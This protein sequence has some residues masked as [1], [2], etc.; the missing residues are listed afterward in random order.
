L[1]LASMK[2]AQV[3]MVIMVVAGLEQAAF[4]QSSPADLSKRSQIRRHEIKSQGSAVEL[5]AGSTDMLISGDAM[6]IKNRHLGNYLASCTSC[7]GITTRDDGIKGTCDN[8]VKQTGGCLYTTN[9]CLSGSYHIIKVGAD[10]GT[11]IHS[12]DLVIIKSLPNNC[13]DSDFYSYLGVCGES[14]N[15]DCQDTS[16]HVRLYEAN[17]TNPVVLGPL[18]DNMMWTISK[19][20]GTGPVLLGAGEYVKFM[21]AQSN[22]DE[23]GAGSVLAVCGECN[24]GTCSA[25]NLCGARNNVYTRILSQNSQ[26]GEDNNGEGGVDDN[27]KFAQ[28]TIHKEVK[29]PCSETDPIY[30]NEDAATEKHLCHAPSKARGEYAHWD[31]AGWNRHL[32]DHGHRQ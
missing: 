18:D 12:G 26:G 2:A 24:E 3:S 6:Q 25:R 27:E 16:A 20:E 31:E 15:V 10:L 32:A 5:R 17:T 21:Q 28:W 13:G 22:A 7:A 29:R 14:A 19:E 8:L 11:T 23:V 9:H 4:A 1:P 30:P